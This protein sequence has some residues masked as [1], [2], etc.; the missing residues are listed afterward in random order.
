MWLLSCSFPSELLAW[1]GCLGKHCP[2]PGR[3]AKVKR[4]E[5]DAAFV[6]CDDA[7]ITC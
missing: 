6:P 3:E 4:M 5:L 1:R 2:S 7:I